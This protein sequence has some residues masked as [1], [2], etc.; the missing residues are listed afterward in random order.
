MHRYFF[1][2][3]ISASLVFFSSCTSN[4]E[5][6]KI[7][8]E[9]YTLENG[10][11]VILHK[12][13][14]DPIV[15][16]TTLV[17]V[18]SSREKPGRTGFA[19]FFE[20][21]SFNDSENVPRGANRKMIPEL[22]GVRNGGTWSDGTIY[23]EVVPKD[24]FEKILW[25][26]SDRMGFMINT[27]TDEALER[28]KQVVKNEKRERV[29]NNPYGHTGAVIR[30][31]LYPEG[32]PY[33]WTVIGDLEDLQAA[34]LEDVKEFYEK[35]YGANNTTLVIAGDIDIAETKKLVEK[36]FGEIR[37]GSTIE[38]LDPMPVSLKETRS[39]YYEDNF[40]KLPELRMVYP[41]IEAYHDDSYALQVLGEILSGSKES[42]LYKV[43]VEE[44]QLAPS[45]YAG[46]NPSELTGEFALVVRA[47]AETDL[48]S[49]KVAIELGLSRFETKGFK[50]VE[51]TR[52]KAKIETDLY[53]SVETV[54]NKSYQLASYNEFAGDPGYITTEANLTR[55][56]TR[57]DVVRVYNQY[58][59]NKYYVM[60]SFV[61]KGQS[62]LAVANAL[63]A[64]VKE[65]EIVNQ[66]NNEN[67]SQGDEAVYE[68]TKTEYDRSEPP[69][70]EVPIFKMPEIWQTELGNGMR[71]YGIISTEIPLVKFDI[72]FKG[73][74]W[75][76][77]IEKTGIAGLL[78]DLLMEGTINKTPN[79]LEQAIELLGASIN[80][81]SGREDMRISVNTLS[82]NF[83]KTLDLV[84]EVLFEPR[85][86]E[87]EFDRLKRELVTRIRGRES[88]PTAIS[89]AVN[90]RLLYGDGH[91]F[92]Q[93]AIA[94]PSS[95]EK[96]SLDD[97]KQYYNNNFNPGLASFHI[98]GDIQKNRALAALTNFSKDWLGKP[99]D[100]P[101][102]KP[103]PQGVDGNLYFVDVP[104]SKQSVIRMSRLALPANHPDYNNLV[105]ADQI[106]GGGSSGRLFQVL[107][108]EKGYTYG[109][110]SFMGNTKE[111]APYIAYTS[112]RANVTRQ[113][114]DLIRELYENYT[115]TF[116]D[117]ELELTKNKIIKD[118]TR[119][120]ESLSSKLNVL[121]QISKF[122]YSNNFIENN[123]KELLEM[124]LDDF[125][126]MI[127]TYLN[128][129]EM[130]YLIIG[131]AKTQVDLLNDFGNTKAIMVDIRGNPL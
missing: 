106:M 34:T 123:Q 24:A 58:I 50:D 3:L 90:Q 95:V 92:G 7:E 62:E 31:N 57:E 97:L 86:D 9:K 85:W 74:Q 126:L 83:E 17:H 41:T 68:K 63:Y 76:D 91:I 98:V 8:F 114:L 15:A 21:M 65:E 121:R 55:A 104:G 37:R 56:V 122:G 46:S 80:F 35:F 6:F 101:E 82:R 69:L 129:D 102:Y 29:D 107:R 109:A 51:L 100:F 23:Y 93:A 120:Y 87:K 115:D 73:G 12:D 108:I 60:T 124:T 79:E 43:I 77:P 38:P 64:D 113:S 118:N 11:E 27:V 59:K 125:H 48:D 116:T 1:Q 119:K 111:I 47:N 45:I 28:E 112:V 49:V 20:H 127:E 103:D 5:E 99:V 89:R 61:P 40:A 18:G 19:H 54:L 26:D 105:Y 81:S 25:I 10:L 53:N 75:L 36:W 131:D 67:V 4:K 66:V 96:I 117:Q 88:N 33:N 78:S 110:F 14:S 130:F 22:G 94:T 52:I 128:E 32:H 70:G 71:T 84:E 42:P 72:S 30:E 44:K 2:L 39:L 16:V 13:D